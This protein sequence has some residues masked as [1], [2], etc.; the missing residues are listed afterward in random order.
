MRSGLLTMA[1]AGALV[2]G[3]ASDAPAS[4][5][6]QTQRYDET[7]DLP[8][9]SPDGSAPLEQVLSDRRSGREYRDQELPL[10]TIGR[11]FWAGQGIT[12]RAGHRTAPSAGARYPIELYAVTS[13]TLMHYLA[14]G[15]QVEQR[16]DTDMLASLAADAFGQDFV[17][18]A[19]VVLVVTGVQ[20]RTE[21]EYG[22]VAGD[23][24]NREAGHV[25]Q[26]ILLQATALDLVAVPVGGFDPARIARRLALPPGEEVL[27]LIP[28][29]HPVGR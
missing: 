1:L 17:S 25:A 26:N 22:A 28:V 19:P 14:E 6:D 18:T 24:V 3:C 10:P 20:A 2:V 7:I 11:L 9:H 29:G 8:P 23:L 4:V 12:D 16:H 5:V 21:A 27:Y 15:H 13:T